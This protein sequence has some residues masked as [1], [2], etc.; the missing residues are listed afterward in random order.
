MAI[1][2]IIG[3]DIGEKRI[4]VA[5]ANT[6]ARISEPL[7][8]LNNDQGFDEA[9]QAVLDEYQPDI[10]VV[11]LPRNMNGL[12]TPQTAYS[13]A[14]TQQKLLK[15]NIPIVFQDETLSSREAEARLQG[16]KY[17]KADIDS[18]AAAIIIEDYL[19]SI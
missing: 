11:G 8:T 3:L 17:T 15:Y 9:L 7:A 4:G 6:I 12:E 19:L 14:F 18:Q 16:K 5:R 2:S 1:N 10:L 13:K